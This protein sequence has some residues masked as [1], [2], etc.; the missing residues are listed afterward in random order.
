MSKFILGEMS[1]NHYSHSHTSN[2]LSQINYLLQP[3]S[4][5]L[6]SQGFFVNTLTN[7]QSLNGHFFH[8]ANKTNTNIEQ[9]N[10][11]LNNQLIQSEKRIAQL[12]IE[13]LRTQISPH[14]VYNVLSSIYTNVKKQSPEIAEQIMLLS[15]IMSYATKKTNLDQEV[16]LEEELENIIRY[17]E[18]QKTRYS[19]N[20]GFSLKQT[21]NA[22]N[23]LIIPLVLLT[24]V[25]NAFKYGD[26]SNPEK[27]ITIVI[28]V[29]DEKLY[30]SCRNKKYTNPQG[31]IKSNGIGLINTKKRLAIKYQDR[32]NLIINDT[33][34]DFEVIFTLKF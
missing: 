23:A 8:H 24:F 25:E 15:E 12:E 19:I 6:H 13:S 4:T 7:N 3:F 26:R 11:S 27:P 16:L 2:H 5:N 20:S 18:L 10:N 32:H 34:E 28:D 30:F 1:I 9:D 17:L 29:A 33:N 31:S 14:F 22:D 21:G